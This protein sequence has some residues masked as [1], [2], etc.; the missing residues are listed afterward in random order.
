M[1]FLSLLLVTRVVIPISFLLWP[2]A[3]SAKSM[4]H[5]FY[6]PRA[7]H[8]DFVVSYQKYAKSIKN[9]VT[10]GTRFKVKFEMDE[11]PERRCTSGIVTGMS[12]LDPYRWPKSKWRCLMV[13]Y[14]KL[15]YFLTDY[16]LIWK[17]KRHMKLPSYRMLCMQW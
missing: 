4:F 17:R 12:D 13:L 10:I 7:T 1:V 5:V 6:S 15:I 16:K 2:N 11:S 9:P 3:I 8:A 14:H